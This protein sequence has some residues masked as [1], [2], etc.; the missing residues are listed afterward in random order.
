M[1]NHELYNLYDTRL[2]IFNDRV[3][4]TQYSDYIATIKE[5][6]KELSKRVYSKREKG[7]GSIRSDSL[8]RSYSTLMD[9]SIMNYDVFK[10]F[11]TLTF[12]ENITD[13]SFAN[14][15]FHNFVRKIRRVVPEFKYLCVP[16]FQKRGA[17]HYHLMTNLDP[18]SHKDIITPQK[19]NDTKNKM[20][21]VKFWLH[22]FTSVFDLNL[23]DNNF[24][25]ALYLGKYF[26]KDIDNR[27]FG[28]RKIM[29]SQNLKKPEILKFNSKEV[30][31][32]DKY[33]K[34][35]KLTTKKTIITTT[36]Y[37]PDVLIISTYQ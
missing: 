5:E 6:F 20:Y 22:G 23:A 26:W 31:K 30:E 7:T 14:K 12:K 1:P 13:L 19:N 17:V 33:L 21:D 11:I 35:K 29:Y 28:H 4:V 10:S 25:V 18:K 24:S 36:D 16:E 32:L 3:E 37:S 9:L 34:N 8:H 27:L 2:K 15:Q